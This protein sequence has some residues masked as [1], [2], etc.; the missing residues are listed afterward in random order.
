MLLPMPPNDSMFLTVEARQRPM[1]VGALHLYQP[2]DGSDSDYVRNTFASLREPVEISPVLLR[3]PARAITSFGQWGWEVPDDFDLR[4]HVRHNALPRP[5]RVLELLA[6]CSRLHSTMLDRSRPLWEAH[7]IE[8]LSDGRFA[9]YLK[10][11]HALVDGIA[12][13]RIMRNALSLDPGEREL[14]PPWAVH[15]P[16]ARPVTE[17]LDDLPSADSNLLNLSSSVV[18]SAL[19]LAAD[20]ARMPAAFTRTV[21]RGLREQ[22]A[23][24]SF[25]APRTIFNVPISGSRRFAAQSWPLSR[26]RAI[27]KS[28]HTTLNDVVLAMCSGA[29]RAYLQ[30]QGALPDASLVAMVPVAL[31]GSDLQRESGNAIGAVMCR[32]ATDLDDAADRLTSITASMKDGK[33]ALGAMSPMQTLAMTALGTAPLL[34]QSLPGIHTVVRPPFNLIISNVP[35]PRRPVYFNGARLDGAYPLSIPFDGQ[36]LNITCSTYASDVSFGLTG[37]RRTVPHLQWLLVHLDNALS[38]LENA[39]GIA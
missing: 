20:A 25:A 22:S 3:K 11:H 23:P 13:A 19:D 4:H 24:V 21:R 31:K 36:A 30:E 1:H 6:L 18:R 9:M 8:G 29:L 32:L 17:V 34:L 27:S 14:P 28:C 38:D 35:G 2:P 16:Q 33:A 15:P 5:G 12:A 39:A 37:C 26:M 10:V 7:L